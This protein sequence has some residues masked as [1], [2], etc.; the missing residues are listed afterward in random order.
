MTTSIA[1]RI[2]GAQNT[3]RRNG[4]GYET[5]R[6]DQEGAIAVLTLARPE[7]LNAVNH[8]MRDELRAFLDARMTD[9]ATRVIVLTGAGRGFCA[10]L[11]IKDP[12]LV[13]P[14]GGLTPLSAYEAQRT[15]S[16][17]ILAMRRCPQPIIGAIN[18]VAVGAGFSMAMACDIRFGT[19][20]TRFQ[21]A[22]INLGLG[23][24]D[25]GSSWLLPRAVGT[26]NA[27]RYLMTGDFLVADEAHRIGFLQAIVDDAELLRHA[28]ELAEVLAGKSPLGLRLT[29]EALDRNTG[30]ASLEDAIRLEDRNQAL[31]I[32]ELAA[33]RT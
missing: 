3:R 28:R 5:I 18:G 12:V 13:R 10:G 31:C 30:G 23:G 17:L 22:Y 25:M 4:M 11:D 20:A 6:H 9:S 7:C 24:A 26:A 29:K 15:F 1:A 19:S 21:A 27:A 2:G 8:V 16:G 33:A 32:A 14:E